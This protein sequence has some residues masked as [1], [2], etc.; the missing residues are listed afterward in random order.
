MM[1]MKRLETW[2]ELN[3]DA[4]GRMFSKRR[5]YLR[6]L[7]F[8]SRKCLHESQ[9]Y[10]GKMCILMK[11]R[12]SLK[13]NVNCS[14]HIASAREK[15]KKTLFDRY[16]VERCYDVNSLD[17]VKEKKR[18]TFFKR[19]GCDYY[20]QTQEFHERISKLWMEKYGVDHPTKSEIVKNRIKKM[21]FERYGVENFFAS[22]EFRRMAQDFE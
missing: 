4:C 12:L 10:D 11:K 7:N 16:G 6:E 1:K 20:F 15:T 13:Y 22:Q 17:V 9:K 19:Y 5:I 18:K 8:C 14:L 3:C 21:C 2:I